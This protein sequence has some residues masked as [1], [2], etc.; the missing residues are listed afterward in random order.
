M[1]PVIGTAAPFDSKNVGERAKIVCYNMDAD[2]DMD[3]L[4]GNADG[5]I[6][7]WENDDG[8][9]ANNDECCELNIPDFDEVTGTDN[10]FDGVDVG[11]NAVPYCFNMAQ[12]A[13]G[14]QP[15]DMDFE[16]LVGNGDGQLKYYRNT[17]TTVAP[18]YTLATGSDDPF[19]GED[20]GTNAAP[21]CFDIDGDGD[22]DCFVG[23][24]DGHIKYYK[25]TGTLLVPVYVEQTGTDNPLSAA[26]VGDDA[27]IT[28]I[29]MD[30]DGDKDCLVGNAK[31][32]VAFFKNI[33]TV[34]VAEYDRLTGTSN[35]YNSVNVISGAAPSCFGMDAQGDHCFVGNDKSIS[36]D[37]LFKYY[38]NTYTSST[39]EYGLLQTYTGD[40]NPFI[41]LSQPDAKPA[42]FDMDSDNDVDCLFGQNDGTWKYYE[43]TGSCSAPAYTEQTGG[44][45]PFNAI[46]EGADAV[47]SCV[48]HAADK[49]DC[50]IGKADGSL[51]YYTNTG[52]K[53]SPVYTAQT[54]ANNPFDG[55]AVGTNAAPNCVDINTD[56]A[57]DCFVGIGDGTIKYFK[58]TG[59]A[60]SPVYEE[61][62][63]ANN[64][65][66][67]VNVGSD[68]APSCF[69]MDGDEDIDCVI[70]NGNAIVYYKNTGT[71]DL[72]Q[73]EPQVNDNPFK[74]FD[75]GAGPYMSCV[76]ME[77]DG[78]I[79]CIMGV[80][81]GNINYFMNYA[82]EHFCYDNGAF[83]LTD[84]RCM[85]SLGFSGVQCA[86]KCPSPGAEPTTTDICYGHGACYTFGG[87]EG[88]CLCE[89]G[90]AGAD[91]LNRTSCDDCTISASDPS[92]FGGGSSGTGLNC[93]LCPGGGTCSGH[94]ACASGAAGAGTC[95]C[96]TGYSG[97]SCEIVDACQVGWGPLNYVCSECAVGKASA[98]GGEC[99]P[100]DAGKYAP[101]TGMSSCLSCGLGNFSV[102]SGSTI[103][104]LCDTGKFANP[105]GRSTC[106]SCESGK[107]SNTIMTSSCTRC[108]PGRFAISTGLTACTKCNAG[109][110]SSTDGLSVCVACT[111]GRYYPGMGAS[112][113][114]Q[115]ATGK[116]SGVTAQTSCANCEAGK[117]VATPGAAACSD[118]PAANNA[119][120]AGHGSCSDGV[121]GTGICACNDGYSGSACTQE[122]PCSPGFGPG[123]V[124][125]CESCA[126]GKYSPGGLGCVDCE[127]GMYQANV[128]ATSCT[129]CDVGKSAGYTGQTACTTCE[130]GK[131]AATTGQAEC[132]A[133]M[134]NYFSAVEGGTVC[135]TC[136]AK[137]TT[138][139]TGAKSFSEC[140]CSPPAEY[141]MRA[142]ECESCPFGAVCGGGGAVEPVAGS[143]IPA[144]DA[145]GLLQATV[146]VGLDFATYGSSQGVK[147][148]LRLALESLT[149]T[150]VGSVTITGITSA[151]GGTSMDVAFDV[152]V[153]VNM[154]SSDVDALIQASMGSRRYLAR[155]TLLFAAVLESA[156]AAENVTTVNIT[157]GGFATTAPLL[158]PVAAS[159]HATYE[160]PFPANCIPANNQSVCAEGAMGP[161]CAI[162]KPGWKTT[163]IGCEKCDD[164]GGSIEITATADTIIFYAII[165]ALFGTCGYYILL[166]FFDFTSDNKKNA[167]KIV[168]MLDPRQK[169]PSP[170]K[171]S[172]H[173]EDL[174]QLLKTLQV[175]NEAAEIEDS[176][177]V[178]QEAIDCLV[179][180]VPV[181]EIAYVIDENFIKATGGKNDGVGRRLEVI[182][183]LVLET[184]RIALEDRCEMEID[185]AAYLATAEDLRMV[186]DYM[187]EDDSGFIEPLEFEKALHQLEL[188]GLDISI[189]NFTNK[190]D[191][192]KFV[193]VIIHQNDEVDES[194]ITK[195]HFPANGETLQVGAE[196]I[197]EK[198]GEGTVVLVMPDGRVAI[199]FLD[200]DM[201]RYGP[202]S[203]S[204]LTVTRLSPNARAKLKLDFIPWSVD[205]LSFDAFKYL[206]TQDD[207]V[208]TRLLLNRMCKSLG[209]K[210]KS[211]VQMEIE[212]KLAGSREDRKRAENQLSSIPSSIEDKRKGSGGISAA[213]GI[214]ALQT[215]AINLE[216]AQN[217][218]ASIEID[219]G[220]EWNGMSAAEQA[221][222]RQAEQ[223]AER[224]A[225]REAERATGDMMRDIEENA[226]NPNAPE[227]NA[228][229]SQQSPRREESGI[230]EAGDEDNGAMMDELRESAEDM[231]GILD[232]GARDAGSDEL[233][234]NA[235]VD[236]DDGGII[237]GM[238]GDM[239]VRD[240]GEEGMTMPSDIDNQE[241]QE[242]FQSAENAMN[243]A[244]DAM[245]NAADAVADNMESAADAVGE[246]ME[247][248][249]EYMAQ[250]LE[251]AEAVAD[252]VADEVAGSM[253][254]LAGA[255]GGSAMDSMRSMEANIDVQDNVDGADM[256]NPLA[257]DMGGIAGEISGS[258]AGAADKAVA[259]IEKLVNDIM[260]IAKIMIGQMQVMTAF[261][262][263]LEVEWPVKMVDFTNIFSVINFDVVTV[264]VPCMTWIT[265]YDQMTMTI[266]MP[267]IMS[268]AIIIGC[269]AGKQCNLVDDPKSQ[270]TALILK[271]IFICFPGCSA[272]P[273]KLFV[274]REIFGK[275][276]ITADYRLECVGDDYVY[277][278]NIALFGIIVYP[279]GCPLL[280]FILLKRNAHK[281]WNSEKCM[282]RLGFIY[283]RYEPAYWWWE[284]IEM[285]RKF[286]LTGVVLFL[287]P[288]SIAQLAMA[289]LIGAYFMAAHVKY[290]PFE[291]ESED[292]L[293]SISLI[294][295]VLVLVLGIMIKA[296]SANKD[297]PE[298]FQSPP[299]ALMVVLTA[300]TTAIGGGLGVYKLLDK[301]KQQ[302]EKLMK[303]LRKFFTCLL[304]L[305][306]VFCC[307][308]ACCCIANEAMKEKEEKKEE[309]YVTQ[310]IVVKD[311]AA[312]EPKPRYQHRRPDN[313]MPTISPSFID[314]GLARSAHLTPS[315]QPMARF[316]GS[317]QS[318]SNAAM[319]T[320]RAS[321]A[322]KD[323]EIAAEEERQAREAFKAT[324]YPLVRQMFTDLDTD[325]SGL[326]DL[327][328]TRQ[329]TVSLGLGLDDAQLDEL[330][331][332]IDTDG[333]GEIDFEEFF[334]WYVTNLHSADAGSGENNNGGEMSAEKREK[335]QAK[336][337]LEERKS[338]LEMVDQLRPM[339]KVMFEEMDQDGSNSLDYEEVRQLTR[340][341]G[342]HLD[343][344]ELQET[345]QDM[346]QD[347][348]GVDFDEFFIWYVAYVAINGSPL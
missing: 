67:G 192:A 209:L 58:N 296:A 347:G 272:A 91:A 244:G 68:A 112:V 81:L 275:M 326:L 311:V 331:M 254:D 108:A 214:A 257:G 53:T 69:D 127:A 15:N 312:T 161:V 12:D 122:A 167:K 229:T 57:I 186:F 72:P 162:C 31:G 319:A 342:L 123:A 86:T 27:V 313:H 84:G 330:I 105:V 152:N 284:I 179:Q 270:A 121:T 87:N 77:G 165:L 233:D 266:F 115:C 137:A 224:E 299:D 255:A 237:E 169:G 133:C 85:C 151:T 279:I 74:S 116:F 28:C 154:K 19:D 187:D 29:D 340:N 18:E 142:G 339:A 333:S 250:G 173:Y 155:R 345:Y 149:T 20:V 174:L 26:D 92:Y 107:Y 5:T 274:C 99:S 252:M 307:C 157:T 177:E 38:K 238:I 225:Q 147:D 240:V 329:L 243:S 60:G 281:L 346:D 263:N 96:M 37:W 164:S 80:T 181:G 206:M 182:E 190:A 320:A 239:D 148:A 288:G 291:E 230:H 119:I 302:G 318:D 146:N 256:D 249:E 30:A 138:L 24:G 98:V 59:T 308:L 100:C 332:N 111:T 82:M 268:I 285:V 303:V 158:E 253:E 336:Q 226:G 44:S 321:E 126:A 17:G 231:A 282:N 134:R 56:N 93:Q 305:W 23:N 46:N 343:E 9:D 283:E 176:H 294:S 324:L 204:K 290:Q 297:Q 130:M 41:A 247:A 25:N 316:G 201:H 34:Y 61:Q 223:A 245:D 269:Y 22:S 71:T 64:P 287:A 14:W 216:F 102:Q 144:Q 36:S 197:H 6:K 227:E 101:S 33:G 76:D 213:G 289:L 188:H 278:T 110:Y 260:G 32:L 51:A 314:R 280:Y 334:D 171:P 52:T 35:P 95:T 196:V 184:R 8:N 277:Y 328:E 62:T 203:W 315:A 322:R 113:C 166:E 217:T 194:D 262:A 264:A 267:I 210:P 335:V 75:V 50:V 309:E 78:D 89:I 215:Q 265:F 16:C 106:D 337:R 208:Q 10:P 45:N 298:K 104:Q 120:C 48:I 11:D 70:G 293:Q 195:A 21:F 163:K 117:F 145:L 43:N 222:Q 198:R 1:E 211:K 295:T 251:Q 178:L 88:S 83:S 128:E 168:K 103:C 109:T 7:Y 125:K 212:S 73:F 258:I 301:L 153:P 132:T 159:S 242:N 150:G 66:N 327:D 221:A 202:E 4:V 49:Y 143:W 273:L 94:G 55:V 235:D 323:A 304:A 325:G 271:L 79:D 306:V 220:P 129:K 141:V 236:A 135:S 246:H 2:R 317:A 90:Y 219:R 42:C 292:N 139:S 341:L 40:L 241:L 200:D 183:T 199:T 3:C 276:Y 170:L 175:S 172:I 180:P 124:I 140:L 47:A 136:P 344:D 286:M 63:G 205:G 39:P 218:Q 118:C 189:M 232:L 97:S 207:P 193:N 191:A 348:G 300:C 234:V 114:T 160:C 131:I 13:A 338:N 185:G 310:T 259:E 248:A 65:F 261:T 156:L 54:G 228:E